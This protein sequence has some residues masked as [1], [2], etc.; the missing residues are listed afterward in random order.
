MGINPAKIGFNYPQGLAIDTDGNIY[1]GD[2]NNQRIQKFTYDGKYV[3]MWGTKGNNKTQLDTP[4][5]LAIDSK[6]F[7]YVADTGNNRIQKF[8][9]N[10]N[11]FPCGRIYLGANMDSDH[12]RT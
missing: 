8:S 7:V 4:R 6:G 5:G 1:V 2:T 3:R 12:L 9:N 10:G 11:L